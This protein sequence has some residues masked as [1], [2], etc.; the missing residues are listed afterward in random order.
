MVSCVNGI[1]VGQQLVSSCRGLGSFV[2][3][4]QISSCLPKEVDRPSE[5]G[6]YSSSWHWGSCEYHLAGTGDHV[7]II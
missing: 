4:V 5:T 1:L 7:S 2:V 3:N 6:C